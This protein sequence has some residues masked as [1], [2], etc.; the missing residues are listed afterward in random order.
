[1]TDVSKTGFQDIAYATTKA[2]LG[3]VP[4]VGAAASELLSLIVTPPIEKR[5][6]KW[7][8]DI[9]RD[10]MELQQNRKVDL[11]SL[12]ENEQFIDAVL[13]ATSFALKTSEN[14]KI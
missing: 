3:S 12:V 6:E 5:R 11:T 4:L 13:Q 10:L 9:G 1:M 7:M 2:V 14:E 8:T